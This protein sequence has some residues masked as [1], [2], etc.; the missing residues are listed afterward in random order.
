MSNSEYFKKS[1]ESW[2]CAA[3]FPIDKEKVYPEH[4]IVQEFDYFQDKLVLDYGSGSGAD[5]FSYLKRG[6]RVICCDIVETNLDQAEDNLRAQGMSISNVDFCH[7]QCSWEIPLD[8]NGVD[9]VNAN[10]VLHH[11]YP[12]AYRVVK[13]LYRVCKPGGLFY[14]M[15]YTEDLRKILDPVVKNF[16]QN[17]NISEEEAFGWA[18][19]GPGTPYSRYYT[20]EQGINFIEEAGF[21]VISYVVYNQRQFRTF[22]SIK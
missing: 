18:T 21:K 10:G 15:L 17:N 14:C 12:H 20:E 2:K 13:E 19:D 22:K 6:N 5:A 11:I 16:M 3:S 1:K 4:G 9:V 8:D 7:L